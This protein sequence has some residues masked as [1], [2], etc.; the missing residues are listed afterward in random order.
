MNMLEADTRQKYSDSTIYAPDKI[1]ASLFEASANFSSSLLAEKVKLLLP[2]IDGKRV[3][4]LGCGNGRH[5]TE[6]AERVA[7][8]VGVDFSLPFIQYA[9]DRFKNISNL[10]FVLADARALPFAAHSFDCVY[11]FAALYYLDDI[12]PVYA[13]LRRILALGGFALIEVGNA[14][15]MATRVSRHYPAIAQH[16]CRTIGS[17]C[18]PCDGTDWW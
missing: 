11:S 15:S 9:A 12:E 10:C 3:L 16:S 1:S 13:E 6:L 5:L 14:R 8:G 17:T 2:H 7:F 18:A 4:D